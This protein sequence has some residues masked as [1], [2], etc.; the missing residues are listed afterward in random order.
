MFSQKSL[1]GLYA[2]VQDIH[3]RERSLLIKQDVTETELRF[4][5]LTALMEEVGELATEVRRQEKMC[6]N[7]KKVDMASKDLICMEAMDVLITTLLLLKKYAPEANLDAYLS[8]KIGK[9]QSRGY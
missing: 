5:S 7:Q 2:Y 1:E 8:E 3:D 4:G 9:N 6:F